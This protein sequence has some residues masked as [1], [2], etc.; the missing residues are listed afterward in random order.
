MTTMT[1]RFAPSNNRRRAFTLIELLVVVSIIAILVGILLPALQKARAA[2]RQIAAAS[3]QRQ[4]MLGIVNYATGND[5]WIPGVNTT[6]FRLWT[7][8]ATGIDQATIDWMNSKSSAPTGSM[9]WMSPALTGDDLPINR[10][11]RFYDMFTK[12]ADPAMRERPAI[13]GSGEATTSGADQGTPAGNA[14]LIK[15]IRDNK[16]PNP[17]GTSYLMPISYQ[18][19]GS[20]A[21]LGTVREEN[22]SVGQEPIL[23]QADYALYRLPSAY[24]PRME[25]IGLMSKKVG[26]ASGFRYFDGRGAPPTV[27]ASYTNRNFMSFLDLSPIHQNS[28]AWG[29][30]T[31]HIPN[32]GGRSRS[33]PGPA[34]W[35]SYRHS[36]RMNAAFFDGHVETLGD[37]ESRN[38]HFWAPSRS[39][40]NTSGPADVA[41][42]TYFSQSTLDRVVRTDPQTHPVIQ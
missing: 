26:I 2:G 33:G 30:I 25:R 1:A 3:T 7:G 36:Q 38:P 5:G 19:M 32:S 27:E 29:Y 21:P 15:Y 40:L 24:R 11:A 34:M 10:E 23:I 20:G 37:L 16:L 4:L 9:D 17:P 22:I 8:Y 13:W 41:A 35:L 39:T 18:L 28:T 31:R 42:K 12:F 14:E 6:G